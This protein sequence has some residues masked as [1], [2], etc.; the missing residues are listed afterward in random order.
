[1]AGR[2]QE[3]TKLKPSRFYASTGQPILNLPNKQRNLVLHGYIRETR[4]DMPLD[5]V[6]LI[7]EFYGM[8]GSNLKGDN[9]PLTIQRMI[10]IDHGFGP[11]VHFNDR[12]T[13]YIVPEY[14]NSRYWNWNI[15]DTAPSPSSP[16]IC[17][18]CCCF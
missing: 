14:D 15:V 13:V 10:N 5:V 2:G 9:N 1:M 17:C 12:V 6:P 11:N 3:L 18:G 4:E 16:G 7:V 8:I